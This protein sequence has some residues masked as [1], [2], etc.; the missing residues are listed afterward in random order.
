[1]IYSFIQQLLGSCVY[2]TLHYENFQR[3]HRCTSGSHAREFLNIVH[4]CIYTRCSIM[5][6]LNATSI[7]N[8]A[9]IKLCILMLHSCTTFWLYS[10]L[11]TMLCSYVRSYIHA[12]IICGDSAWIGCCIHAYIECYIRAYIWW[13]LHNMLEA[14]VM[15]AL[16]AT[17]DVWTGWYFHT[18]MQWCIRLYSK[19]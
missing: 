12:Y 17:F 2:Y 4:S 11:N 15:H 8:H 18:S 13:Y 16:R 19:C 1:M 10:C 5:H 6:I 3:S 14:L 9:F 7:M